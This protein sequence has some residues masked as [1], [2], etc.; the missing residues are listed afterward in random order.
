MAEVMAKKPLAR[1]WKVAQIYNLEGGTGERKIKLI[2]RGKI[3]PA[4]QEV[5]FFRPVRAAKKTRP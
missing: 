5:L 3:G 4:E 2:G 1:R